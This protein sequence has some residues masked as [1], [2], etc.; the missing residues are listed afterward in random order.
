MTARAMFGGLVQD[1]RGELVDVRRVGADEVYVVREDG[2]DWHLEAGRVDAAIWSHMKR[3]F[4]EHRDQIPPEA[5]QALT[6][7]DIFQQAAIESALDRVDEIER[8]EMPPRSPARG[9]RSRLSCSM[10]TRC[11]SPVTTGGLSPGALPPPPPQAARENAAAAVAAAMAKPV[12]YRFM[13][14]LPRDPTRAAAPVPLAPG[15]LHTSRKME[16]P[17]ICPAEEL[18]RPGLGLFHSAGDPA[19]RAPRCVQEVA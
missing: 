17:P 9:R 3:M 12:M 8:I 16:A 1:S 4:V 15:R 11:T 7:G 18:P 5:L 19:K 13:V 6:N 10:P 2:F 14:G